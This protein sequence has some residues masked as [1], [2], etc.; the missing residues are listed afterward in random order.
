MIEYQLKSWLKRVFF[1]GLGVGIL[2][3]IATYLYLEDSLAAFAFG[4]FGFLKG[5]AYYALFTEPSLRRN[6]G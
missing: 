5:L 3:A 4:I 2:L 1:T 6:D